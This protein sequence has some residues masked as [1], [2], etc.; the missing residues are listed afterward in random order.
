MRPLT[1]L[2]NDDGIMSPDLAAVAIAIKDLADV[3]IVAPDSSESV[4]LFCV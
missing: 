3:V 4:F 1:L 2:T